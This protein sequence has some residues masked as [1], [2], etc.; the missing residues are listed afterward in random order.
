MLGGCGDENSA[1]RVNTGTASN[2]NVPTVSGTGASLAKQVPA[3]NIGAEKA[4]IPVTASY[5]TNPVSGGSAVMS[6]DGTVLVNSKV[7]IDKNDGLVTVPQNSTNIII[8]LAPRTNSGP[9]KIV[10]PKGLKLVAVLPVERLKGGDTS[11]RVAYVFAKPHTG[12]DVVVRQATIVI[13]GGKI[14]TL[15]E[16]KISNLYQS[17]VF[18]LP[19]AFG[20]MLHPKDQ[21]DTK[22]IHS[23]LIPRGAFD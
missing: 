1:S 20:V 15:S 19:T 23:V 6:G 9:W 5:T 17:Q 14:A 8:N 3:L 12:D 11:G 10:T 16:T 22:G 4:G 21:P 7:I 13:S 2:A 18:P